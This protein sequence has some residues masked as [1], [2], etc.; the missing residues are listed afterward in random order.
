MCAFGSPGSTQGGPFERNWLAYLVCKDW[1]LCNRAQS[2]TSSWHNV[3]V[4]AVTCI[5][6][7]VMFAG[8]LV[9]GS[10]LNGNILLS[11]PPGGIRTA[12]EI[13]ITLHCLCAFVILLNPLSLDMEEF[14]G[15]PNSMYQK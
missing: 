10:D 6:L 13:I 14:F 1:D 9:Y 3:S 4:A 11:I 2:Y 15:I 12:C 7:P 8:Y 5:Y